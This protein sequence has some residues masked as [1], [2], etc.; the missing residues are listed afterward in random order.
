MRGQ[1][2]VFL[3]PPLHPLVAGEGWGLSAS[4]TG[5]LSLPAQAQPV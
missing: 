2:K 1:W 4:Q 3:G 5:L